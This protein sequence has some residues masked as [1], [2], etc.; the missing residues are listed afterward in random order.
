[1]RK[2]TLVRIGLLGAALLIAAAPSKAPAKH[3]PRHAP[4]SSAAVTCSSNSTAGSFVGISGDYDF[5]GGSQSGVVAGTDNEACDF[6][7]FIGGGSGNGIGSGDEGSEGEF[8]G[9]GSGNTAIGINDFVGAGEYNS[10]SFFDSFVGGGISNEASGA[11][12]FVGGG[13]FEYGGDGQQPSPGNIASGN[14]A[15]V[16]AG[17]LNLVSGNGS[18]IG[19]GGFIWANNR[20]TTPGNQISSTDAFIGA[21]DQ[22]SIG[23]NAAFIGGGTANEVT[24]NG[25]DGVIA[26]G[27]GNGVT[28]AYGAVAGGEN[29]GVTAAR[30]S[31]PSG[32]GF[33]GGGYGNA[34]SGAYGTIAG[35]TSNQLSGEYAT[36]AGGDGNIASGEN[37][38]IPGGYRNLASGKFSFAAGVGSYA[39]T[40]GSFVW[41]DDA[42][43]A[44]HLA[45]TKA[46]QF[47]ARATGG[48]IFLTNAGATT[49]AMLAPGSGAWSNS[50][51][52]NLKSGVSHIDDATILAK[53]AALPVS[54]WSYTSERGVRHVGPMAQ[55]FYAAFRVGEDDRHIATIDEDGVAL[56]AIKALHAENAGLRDD[57][58]SLRQ[59]VATLARVVARMQLRG[60]R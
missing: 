3:H 37:A 15:F 4:R 19:A 9:A 31:A 35:G 13:D 54:E 22:N 48:F 10:T 12:A 59:Q 34:N 16:G 20:Q 7:S 43:G 2:P 46:N 57:V 49:G 42:T 38:A 60:A 56:A 44:K 14:D 41:S 25:L 27:Q 33:V 18:F 23:A 36:I 24:S 45:T 51:D 53:V 55:D 21:G 8:I 11:G 5:A 47:L 17:D 6:A 40:A 28:A 29:N 26:G 32:Y 50:S 58:R 1:V 39:T 52:R 30:D